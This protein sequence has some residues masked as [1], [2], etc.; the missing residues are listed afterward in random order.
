MSSASMMCSVF[1]SGGGRSE[2]YSVKSV[3]ERHEP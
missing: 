3:G 1:G 2:V